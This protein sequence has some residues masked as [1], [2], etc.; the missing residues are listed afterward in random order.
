MTPPAGS[1]LWLTMRGK[2]TVNGG[3]GY[4]YLLTAVDGTSDAM[5]LQV[6]N[7][8]GVLVYDNGGTTPIKSGSIVVK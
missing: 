7:A 4:V 3:S 1:S 8:S 2:C 5:R 6:W